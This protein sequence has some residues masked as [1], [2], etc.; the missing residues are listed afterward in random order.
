MKK[1]ILKSILAGI[2][3][4]LGAFVY[5]S[6]VSKGNPYVGAFLFSLGLISV[7]V[8]EANLYTGKIGEIKFNKEMIINLLLIII[9]NFVG[10][11]LVALMG[12]SNQAVVNECAT[13]VQAKL[14]K[15]WYQMIFDSLLC[16]AIIHLAVLMYRKTKSILIVIICIMVFILSGFEHCIAN[17]F[18]YV[19]GYQSFTPFAFIAFLI[20]ILGNSIG[21]ILINLIV[22]SFNKENKS[23]EQ[24]PNEEKENNN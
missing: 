20:Y 12:L 9:F 19:C 16:G 4:G 22:S 24:L 2:L 18:Y 14:D 1:L 23:P 5:T 8:L 6:C 13:I 17:L 3:I 21:A 10:I 15:T 7:F 11:A